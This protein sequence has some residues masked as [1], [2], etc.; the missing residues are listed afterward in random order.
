MLF[1]STPGYVGVPLDFCSTRQA[2][3]LYGAVSALFE[4]GQEL[5]TPSWMDKDVDPLLTPNQIVSRHQMTPCG[6]D[7]TTHNRLQN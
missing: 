7:D 5:W 6:W 2:I 4:I 3:Y 1:R